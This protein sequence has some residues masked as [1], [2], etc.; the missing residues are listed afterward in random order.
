MATLAGE[1]PAYLTA[2]ELLAGG[3]L[4]H[5]V[6]VPAGLG[7]PARASGRVRLR[8]LTVADLQLITRAAREMA[9]RFSAGATLIAFGS[10]AAAADAR[11]IAV[12]FV[13]LWRSRVTVR[14]ALETTTR[15]M[16]VALL[17]VFPE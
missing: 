12:E 14:A 11:H 1:R 8:P 17:L 6:T 4:R 9:L 15:V 16:L 13:H 10:G 2:D 5:E 3:T 7:D